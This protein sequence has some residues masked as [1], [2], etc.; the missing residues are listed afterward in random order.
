MK[1]KIVISTILLLAGTHMIAMNKLL[2]KKL[3]KI[4]KNDRKKGMYNYK[5]HLNENNFY[6][7][8]RFKSKPEPYFEKDRVPEISRDIIKICIWKNKISAKEKTIVHCFDRNKWEKSSDPWH[9]IDINKQP[10]IKQ[11]AL[12]EQQTL[13]KRAKAHKEQD[14]DSPEGTPLA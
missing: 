6:L 2:E 8:L 1:T 11:I 13:K 4:E 10:K 7:E 9:T 12:K 14:L 5:W 3:K